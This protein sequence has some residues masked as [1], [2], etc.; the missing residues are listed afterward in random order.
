[1]RALVRVPGF[2]AAL[3]RDVV[4]EPLYLPQKR[5]HW[6][7]GR[8]LK[9]L[10]PTFLERVGRPL[11]GV[12]EV[13]AAGMK[14]G[15]RT[16]GDAAAAVAAAAAA[17]EGI[18]TVLRRA[19]LS[20]ALTRL[21]RERRPIGTCRPFPRPA[22]TMRDNGG[23]KCAAFDA[24]KGALAGLSAKTKAIMTEA[25]AFRNTMGCRRTRSR[26][27][28]EDDERN[29]TDSRSGRRKGS[30][31]TR[32]SARPPRRRYYPRPPETGVFLARYTLARVGHV[33]LT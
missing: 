9:S 2:C 29:E 23:N 31:T 5:L 24:R 32:R 10:P 17:E 26:N 28:W 15:C 19:S 12:Q 20:F 22:L 8:Q 4:H 1:V 16:K 18:D 25:A 7:D 6:R 13:I 33:G 3:Q 21:E 27:R 11:F 14:I 30:T